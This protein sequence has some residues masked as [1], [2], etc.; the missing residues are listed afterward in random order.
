MH[1]L[2]LDENRQPKPAG[3]R[4][5]AVGSDRLSTDNSVPSGVNVS[6]P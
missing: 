5:A 3:T 1:A 4:P 6:H 2:D